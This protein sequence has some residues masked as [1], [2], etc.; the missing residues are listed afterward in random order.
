MKASELIKKLNIVI[1]VYGDKEVVAERIMFDDRYS[2]S[3][4]ALV[5]VGDRLLLIPFASEDERENRA[6]S[7][8]LSYS[9]MKIIK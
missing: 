1:E 7:N 9:G 8:P 2:E 6:F 3:I 5:I 4:D